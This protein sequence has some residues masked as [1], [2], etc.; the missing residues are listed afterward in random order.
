MVENY[1]DSQDN[2]RVRLLYTELCNDQSI[3]STVEN[4]FILYLSTDKTN[5]DMR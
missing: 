3:V 1:I 5:S 4:L 2:Q